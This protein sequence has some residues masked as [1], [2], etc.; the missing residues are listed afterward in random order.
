MKVGDL[1]RLKRKRLAVKD[2][3]GSTPGSAHFGCAE[4][5]NT[6]GASDNRVGTGFGFNP[7]QV[8]HQMGLRVGTP[9]TK[10]SD[11]PSYSSLQ[12]GG[13]K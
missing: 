1:V 5:W 7:R 3:S 10:K 8:R 6:E 9:P 13:D 4:S 11:A 2:G 12:T